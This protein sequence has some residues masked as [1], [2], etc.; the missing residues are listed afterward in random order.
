MQPVQYSSYLGGQKLFLV[1]YEGISLV[2]HDKY[3][4]K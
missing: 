4:L 2:T 1:W 3:A